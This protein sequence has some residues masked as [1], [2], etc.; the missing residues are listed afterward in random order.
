ML[1]PDIVALKIIKRLY[2]N[3]FGYPP[4]PDCDMNP[5]SAAQKMIDLINSPRPTMI[6]R[7]GS[8]E[9]TCVNNYVGVQN[10]KRNYLGYV[11]GKAA[12]WWWNPSHIIKMHE[13]SGFFPPRI[14]EIERFCQL[15]LE[16]MK[17]LD[18][19]GSWFH[20]ERRFAKE[21]QN[22]QKIDLDLLVPFFSKTPWTSA[23][24]GKKVLVVHPFDVTI[25]RQFQ[26]KEQVFPNGLLPDFELQTIR[27][28]QTIAGESTHF[29]DWFAVYD[30][31][32]E[33]IDSKDY[34]I[35]LLGCGSYGLP[36]AAHVK[37][38]G[39]KSI[40]MGG[41]LQLIFGIRGKRWENPNYNERFNIAAHMNENWVRASEEEKPQQAQQLEGACF[42]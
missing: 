28:I 1:P 2:N 6:S 11:L 40:H 21:L 34:D 4:K 13:L 31:L 37:R 25:T 19:I 18:L 33:Q 12:P 26:R 24:K 29:K 39:K 27:A 42:W 17:Q 15:M 9:L 35:C 22:V 30:Y 7:F 23:L 10:G 3:I 36:L 8:T 41:S 38:M 16:D 5:D 20:L 14:P 32:K